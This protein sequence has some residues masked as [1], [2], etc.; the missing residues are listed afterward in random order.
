MK[1]NQLHTL[2]D[3][4]AELEERGEALRLVAYKIFC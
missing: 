4:G 1:G 3:I 2:E